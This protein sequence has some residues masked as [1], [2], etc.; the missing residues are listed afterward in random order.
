MNISYPLQGKSFEKTSDF[1]PRWGRQHKGIDLAADPGTRVVSVAD[2][3]IV[4]SGNFNDGFG[5]VLIKHVTEDGKVFYTR[6]AHL[7]KWYVRENEKITK[8]EKIGE[9]GGEKGHPNAG[10]SEG[11]HLHFELLDGGLVAKDPEPYLKGAAI[12]ALA[13]T[14]VLS[15]DDEDKDD[16]DS[17]EKKKP[18]Y[19]PGK[20]GELQKDG[21]NLV[22]KIMKT[23]LKVIT[24]AAA[25]TSLKGLSEPKEEDKKLNEEI[26]RI[27]QLL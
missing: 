4:K 14:A 25:V 5:Q 20:Y 1:G 21:N 3:Q 12:G 2:G 24:P 18:T 17:K 10:R 19:T 16:E 13:T 26:S 15:K 11:P 9:S 22:D 23:A 6:Y 7:N 8:G 27:K